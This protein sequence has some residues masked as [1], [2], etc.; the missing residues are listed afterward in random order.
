MDLNCLTWIVSLG[1]AEQ[2]RLQA[3]I[4]PSPEVA[5]TMPH[6]T[7]QALAGGVES[8]RVLTS[9]RNENFRVLQTFGAVGTN[10]LVQNK[11]YSKSIE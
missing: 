6:G 7:L 4:P 2:A 9:I 8:R 1:W 10:H 3:E 5:Q 11:T